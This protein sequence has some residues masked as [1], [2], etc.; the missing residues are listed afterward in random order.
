MWTLKD[1]VKIV[2][3]KEGV[4]ITKDL[5]QKDQSLADLILNNEDY[6]KRYGHN[7][8]QRG[9]P[10]EETG[11]ITIPVTAKKKAETVTESAP[12]TLPE[13]SSTLTAAPTGGMTLNVREEKP[14]SPSQGSKQSKHQTAAPGSRGRK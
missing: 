14:K 10:K 1:P 6:K 8:V 11:E 12:V 2:L 3:K 5:L 9:V 7:L 13:S 4:V